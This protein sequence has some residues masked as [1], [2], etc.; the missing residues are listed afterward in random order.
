[1]EDARRMAA[2]KA[3]PAGSRLRGPS[4]QE[5]GVSSNALAGQGALVT[6]AESAVGR[7]SVAALADAGAQVAAMVDDGESLADLLQ[8]GN[9]RV[10]ILEK[11]GTRPEHWKDA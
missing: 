4:Q 9:G 5:E 2:G 11:P 3:G 7:A 10:H 6:G 8:R 1:M